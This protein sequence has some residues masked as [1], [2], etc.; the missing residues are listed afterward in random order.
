MRGP[1]PEASTRGRADSESDDPMTARLQQQLDETRHALRNLQIEHDAILDD[2]KEL[3][4][5]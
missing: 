2:N 4:V 1:R 3:E 5:R